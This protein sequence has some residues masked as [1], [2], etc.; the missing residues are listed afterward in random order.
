M[1]T[2]KRV[3]LKKQGRDGWEFASINED[4]VGLA[5]DA[6]WIPT[7]DE[8]IEHVKRVKTASTAAGVAGKAFKGLTFGA[9]DAIQTEL[10]GRDPKDVAA[11][12]E[13]AGAL[14]DL[15]EIAA[16]ATPGGAGAKIGG[17][18]AKGLGGKA[19]G[20]IVGAGVGL[21]LEAGAY[22]AGSMVSER[23]LGGPEITAE[24]FLSR[25]GSS[26]GLGAILGVAGR[27]AIVAAPKAGELAGKAWDKLQAS[28]AE[29]AGLVTGIV[30]GP[31]AGWLARNAAYAG[32]QGRKATG[33]DAEKLAAQIEQGEVRAFRAEEKAARYGDAASDAYNPLS[34]KYY[35]AEARKQHAMLELQTEK[36]RQMEASIVKQA[37]RMIFKTRSRAAVETAVEGVARAVRVATPVKI[38][39]NTKKRKD[40]LLQV[41]DRIN[42]LAA[43]PLKLGDIARDDVLA[44]LTPEAGRERILRASRAVAYLKSVEPQT[45]RPPFSGGTE[46]VS[47]AA[48]SNYEKTLQAVI[49][50]HRVLYHG[51]KSGSLSPTQVKAIEVVYP[52]V[53][54]KLRADVLEKIGAAEKAGKAIEHAARVRLGILLNMPLDMSLAP[55]NYVQIQQAMDARFTANRPPPPSKNPGRAPKSGDDGRSLTESQRREGGIVRD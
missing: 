17:A 50:P 42:E 11:E 54:E 25:V 3:K 32:R 49:D 43:D 47:P 5:R 27:G 2:P 21:G 8:E 12:A 16:F 15:A 23:A 7:S 55:E 38:A 1:A 33:A 39:P 53:L 29:A 4:E 35:K 34:A 46:L 37:D 44:E 19:A 52:K 40:V 28:R 30:A 24:R 6:G 41:R 18:V 13:A 22:T 31:K 10:L 14:G 51:L 20:K 48:L 36:L 26:M 9:G 45:Y